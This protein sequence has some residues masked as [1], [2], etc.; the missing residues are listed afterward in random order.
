MGVTAAPPR[1]P[2]CPRCR[3]NS[4][5]PLSKDGDKQRHQCLSCGD[6]F[7]TAALPDDE[8]APAAPEAPRGSAYVPIMT[9]EPGSGPASVDGVR[10]RCEKCEKPY[11]HLGKKYEHHI[12][13]CKGEK[14]WAEPKRRGAAVKVPAADLVNGARRTYA[15]YL[16]SLEARRAILAGELACVDVM[17][18]DAKKKLE[19]AGGAPVPFAQGA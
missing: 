9:P 15:V 5:V 4:T 7:V 19:A 13:T 18:A 8:P 17:I 12:A 1:R 11:Y 6:T 3:R 2:E 16:E 10:A 14:K